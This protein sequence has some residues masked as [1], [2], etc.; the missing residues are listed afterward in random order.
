MIVAQVADPFSIIT[1]ADSRNRSPAWHRRL[2]WPVAG[3]T[4]VS[5]DLQRGGR[6]SV[7]AAQIDDA[8][9]KADRTVLLVAEGAACFAASWWARLSP[10]HYVSRVGGALLLEPDVAS[11]AG[12]FASPSIALPFPSVVLTADQG[13]V[14]HDA[15]LDRMVA[16]W[17]SRAM[18]GGRSRL[19]PPRAW[20]GAQ[21]L[22]VRLTG[23]VVAN[24]VARAAALSGR[25]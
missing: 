19:A 23:A 13:H 6:Q 12:D 8:V 4:H 22:L 1:I 17:G 18:A 15:D 7:W 24:D 11:R 14:A 25:P 10:S 21:R 5:L 2:R 16:S 3:D 20:H 9:L